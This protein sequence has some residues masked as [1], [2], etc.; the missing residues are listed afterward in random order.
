MLLLP[1]FI[2]VFWKPSSVLFE[3]LSVHLPN[4][5]DLLYPL[6]TGIYILLVLSRDSTW[7]WEQNLLGCYMWGSLFELMIFCA[8]LSI[9]LKITAVHF[10]KLMTVESQRVSFDLPV[11]VS[12]S[13]CLQRD[14]SGSSL[15][16]SFVCTGTYRWMQNPLPKY[17]PFFSTPLSFIYIVSLLKGFFHVKMTRE[18]FFLAF[19]ILLGLDSF[20]FPGG[21]EFLWKHRI[22]TLS[23]GWS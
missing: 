17:N 8:E 18:I 23:W 16:E 2:L 1:A 21:F 11:I 5:W 14:F 12:L 13:L 20:L 7:I 22:N 19:C 3:V 10:R 9:F 4:G 6:K 15:G